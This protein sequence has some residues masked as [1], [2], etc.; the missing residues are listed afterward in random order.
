MWFS[1][2]AGSIGSSAGSVSFPWWKCERPVSGSSTSLVQVRL[3]LRGYIFFLN[4]H[5]LLWVVGGGGFHD[6]WDLE[7]SRNP[8]ITQY[9]HL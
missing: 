5:V 3:L 8:T 1:S 2:D 9:P 6:N 4:K 7:I